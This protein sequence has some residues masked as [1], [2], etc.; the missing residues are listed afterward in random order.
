[1]FKSL[2]QQIFFL[3]LAFAGLFS[4]VAMG[5]TVETALSDNRAYV[6]VPISLF[7]RI[8]NA[9][10][11]AQP[12]IPGVD[13]LQI[14]ASGVPSRSSQ[15]TIIN[16][17]RTDRT[18]VTYSWTVTP[19]RSGTFIIPAVSVQVDG[20]TKQTQPVGLR[21]TK[22]ETG[23]LLYVEV[24]GKQDKI[25]VGESLDL[26][27]HVLIKPYHDQRFDVTLSP[28]D[29]WDLVSQQHSDW[30]A[31]EKTLE[32]LAENRQRVTGQ[33]VLR[34]DAQG[35]EQVYYAYEIPAT[36]YPTRP[37]EVDTGD[38]Q[39]VLQYPT[40]LQQNRSFFSSGGLSIA[41]ARPLVENA[42]VPS[43]QV[44][45]I[46]EVGRPVDYRGAVGHYEMIT[47]AHPQKVKAGD[48]IT[49][50]I[51]IRGDGPMELVQSPPLSELTAFTENF[52]V[53]DESLA[54][55]V[56]GDVKVFSVDIRPRKSGI[57]EIPALPLS[58][59]DPQAEKFETVFSA[60]IPIEVEAADQ[61][62]LSS[63]VSSSAPRDKTSEKEGATPL[64]AIVTNHH[65][66]L[67]LLNNSGTSAIWPIVLGLSWAPALFLILAV[68]QF[69]PRFIHRWDGGYRLARKQAEKDLA[70][71]TTAEAVYSALLRYIA[72]L[73][74]VSPGSLTRVEAIHS[75]RESV[76]TE[77]LEECDQLLATCEKANYAGIS[78]ADTQGLTE[79]AR[80]LLREIG[81]I[82][83]R[84]SSRGKHF[85]RTAVVTAALC[86]GGL[87]GPTVGELSAA[88]LSHAQKAEILEEA[89]V[90][91]QR[92]LASSA[93]AAVA[94]ESFSDAAQKYQLLIDQGTH[95]A[96]LYSNLA[97]AYLQ[98]GE[99]ALALVNYERT[100]AIVP[101]DTI[102]IAGR[103]H[104]L[105]LLTGEQQER[106]SFFHSIY[107]WNAKFPEQLRLWIG[108]F[109]WS[110]FWVALSGILVAGLRVC[111]PV[112]LAAAAACI[113]CGTSLGLQAW[114]ENP[115]K[116][117]VVVAK[118]VQLREGNGDGF[119]PLVGSILPEGSRFK[120]MQ[121]RGNWIQVRTSD[122]LEGWLSA[123]TTE[124]ITLCDYRTT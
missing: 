32:E 84:E 31:F 17:R 106:A 74:N 14:E 87:I 8:S 44:I 82:N 98:T 39:V 71:A 86:S 30:G 50:N 68:I 48:P 52:K 27:L 75:I 37:G 91:F 26:V 12:V 108:V 112:A 116:Q 81:T 92:G 34:A 54:G 9:E 42:K 103:D 99:V 65:Q 18:T 11:Y 102:A 118:D 117:G 70:K 93:D 57:T 43:T 85:L 77:T 100:L 3:N 38:V 15:T 24:D 20:N 120:V 64:A 122:G 63:V 78:S 25:Y 110:V 47:R 115:V 41:Q 59:F 79:R 94:K 53:P 21:A 49:L 67:D 124:M 105:F 73:T 96:K 89:S 2:L 119:A 13:G 101:G 55:V 97:A 56:E 40:A 45:P 88:D 4:T 121:K 28:S 5:A 10:K 104:A 113:L 76:A 109:F 29:M 90:A 7:V 80:T 16:G 6:G 23:D 111:R 58:F 35:E 19:R 95:N 69:G 51:G 72:A 1:M 61:L 123:D 33:Q 36:I 66:G 83:P 62:A 107:L 114:Y 22:S 60:P 46:P